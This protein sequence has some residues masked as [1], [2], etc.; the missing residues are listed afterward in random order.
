MLL[1]VLISGTDLHQGRIYIRDGYTSGAD[2]VTESR[3]GS[4]HYYE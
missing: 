1:L 2:P 3:G 4:S